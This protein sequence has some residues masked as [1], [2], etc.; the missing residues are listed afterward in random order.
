MNSLEFIVRRKNTKNK[1]LITHNSFGLTF[2]ELLIT[3]GIFCVVGFLLLV[4]VVNSLGVFYKQSTKVSGGININDALSSVRGNIKEST[5]VVESYT[6]GAT[7][8]TSSPTTLVFTIP[9]I[10]AS[11]N[12]I[13]NT[14]DYFVFYLSGNILKFKTFPNALSVRKSQDQ[15]FSTNVNN[16][17][18]KYY[19]L[20]SPPN[21][22]AIAAAKKVRISLTLKEKSGVGY[23]VN[24]ATTEA[25]LRND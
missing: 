2:V 22:V 24:T 20:S 1:K 25:S 12:I 5:G 6:I 23:T 8:Y 17:N 21:E 15:I 11:N 7:T 19:D 13:S 10:D 3:M 4:I 14:Y 18:I 9:S 16:L